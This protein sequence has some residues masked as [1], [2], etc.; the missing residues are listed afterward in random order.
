LVGVLD[1]GTNGTTELSSNGLDFR[2][3]LSGDGVLEGLGG[4]SLGLEVV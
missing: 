1:G 4:N 3:G 2:W